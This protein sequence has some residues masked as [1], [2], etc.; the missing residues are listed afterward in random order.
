[1]RDAELQSHARRKAER[2][3]AIIYWRFF[4]DEARRDLPF[5]A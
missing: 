2:A 1:M 4:C 3:F 5:E